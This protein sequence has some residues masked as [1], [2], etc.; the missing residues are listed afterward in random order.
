MYDYLANDTISE[1]EQ[2]DTLEQ[3]KKLLDQYAS[4]KAR[5]DALENDLAKEKKVFN[6][7][8]MEDIPNLL[9]SKGISE[10]KLPDKRK[11]I[12]KPDLNVTIT[13]M[14]A[15]S[16]FLTE[17]GDSE[18]LKTTLEVGKL[19]N[20]IVNAIRKLLATHLELYPEVT[21]KVHPATLKKYIKELCFVSSDSDP[22][23]DRIDIKD[24][25]S[26]IRAY[27]FNKTIVK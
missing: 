1:E 25:P 18:I 15:F 22:F 21:Q 7:L 13:D 24:L 12:V 11:V 19:D 27:T 5:V 3:L 8:S 9:L 4:A 2:V 23:E 20:S 10:I 17:R 14:E 6:Q 26:Y 16:E